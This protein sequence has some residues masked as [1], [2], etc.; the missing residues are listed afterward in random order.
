[1]EGAICHTGIDLLYIKFSSLHIKLLPKLPS[2]DLKN[3][4]STIFIF[5]QCG[6]GSKLISQREA[7]S[8]L[9]EFSGLTMFPTIMKQL[10]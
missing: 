1:M 9:M 8:L 6:F 4:L 3:D 5:T 7:R 10:A 2:V